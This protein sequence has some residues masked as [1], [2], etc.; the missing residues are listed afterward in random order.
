M[1]TDIAN[2]ITACIAAIPSGMVASYGQI[3]E[4]AGI[5]RGHRVV[6]KFLK[7]D[8]SVDDLPWHRVIRA[9]GKLGF[10]VGSRMFLQQMTQLKVEGV[11]AKNNRI[12]MKRYAWQPTL[13]FI[14]FHPDL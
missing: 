8:N 7:Q 13:D 9:D 4:L 14:L 5:A 6:A 3:A 1:T 12:D 11:V 2:K 10:P